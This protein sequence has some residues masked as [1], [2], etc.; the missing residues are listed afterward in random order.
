MTYEPGERW[1]LIPHTGVCAACRNVYDLRRGCW[2]SGTG[3]G[4]ILDDERGERMS[5]FQFHCP[6][7]G[8]IHPMILGDTSKADQNGRLIA[9][10]PYQHS[11]S[12]NKGV[13]NGN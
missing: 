12:N 11:F 6:F 5:K 13:S 8:R 1:L 9:V 2:C 3:N 10:C 4:T 7:C